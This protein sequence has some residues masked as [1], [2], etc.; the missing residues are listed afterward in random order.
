MV[1]YM[2]FTKNAFS[3]LVFELETSCK[4]Q[5]IVYSM[6]TA[7]C[8]FRATPTNFRSRDVINGIFEKTSI[9]PLFF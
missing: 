4:E 8:H 5:K 9:T 7:W 6:Q 1:M 2:N 3:K